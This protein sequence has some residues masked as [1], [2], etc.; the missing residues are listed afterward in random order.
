MLKY[1]EVYHASEN[2]IKKIQFLEKKK[3]ENKWIVNT[4]FNYY[5]IEA[6]NDK[7]LSI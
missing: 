4:Q 7:R 5:H 6:R 3:E 1:F 2:F